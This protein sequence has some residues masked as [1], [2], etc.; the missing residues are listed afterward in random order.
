MKADE[1]EYDI[2]EKDEWDYRNVLDQQYFH[3][4]KANIDDSSSVQWKKRSVLLLSFIRKIYVNGCY[5]FD[6]KVSA[7][8]NKIPKKAIVHIFISRTYFDMNN[9]FEGEATYKELERLSTTYWNNVYIVWDKTLNGYI[10]NHFHSEFK[11]E[12]GISFNIHNVKVKWTSEDEHLFV[13]QLKGTVVNNKYNFCYNKLAI[14]LHESTEQRIFCGDF[15][16]KLINQM[17][18]TQIPAEL[19]Q[20][21]QLNMELNTIKLIQ[22]ENT[23]LSDTSKRKKDTIKLEEIEENLALIIDPVQVQNNKKIK[24]NNDSSM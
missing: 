16:M 17:Y 15:Q 5:R 14:E 12:S 24:P 11:K 19:Y 23:A 9:M 7:D 3:Q 22:L 10:V 4:G 13:R 6:A 8:M 1:N 2:L 21:E 20:T 18:N